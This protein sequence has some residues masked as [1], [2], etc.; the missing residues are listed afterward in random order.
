[1]EFVR[2][3]VEGGMKMT[4]F[5]TQVG[6]GMYCVQVETDRKEAYDEIQRVARSFVDAEAVGVSKKENATVANPK[7]AIDE[8][9]EALYV[10]SEIC[11]KYEPICGQEA[12]PFWSKY[13]EQCAL[14]GYR[15][16]FWDT[17]KW[18]EQEEEK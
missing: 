12:C 13:R 3:S 16:D 4:G 18:R 10:V 1:M 11:S 9:K 6:G 8:L 14:I 2:C 5:N 7:T 17:A 15:P